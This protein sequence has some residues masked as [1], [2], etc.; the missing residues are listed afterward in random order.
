MLRWIRL[1][2]C[3]TCSRTSR[4]GFAAIAPSRDS[5]CPAKRDLWIYVPLDGWGVGIRR[6]VM[7]G[8]FQNL[9]DTVNGSMAIT[10]LV[11]VLCPNLFKVTLERFD[12]E[13]PGQWQTFPLVWGFVCPRCGRQKCMMWTLGA[14]GT[15]LIR[16]DIAHGDK[17][18]PVARA[19]VS[20]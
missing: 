8:L 17:L 20:R 11:K 6:N 13:G 5:K 19:R 10:Y 3:G 7:A 2:V 15:T 9:S 12:S 14:I 18:L 1:L 16:F 4:I